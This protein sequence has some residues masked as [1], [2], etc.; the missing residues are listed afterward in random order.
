MSKLGLIPRDWSSRYVCVSGL[1][2][3][4]NDQASILLQQNEN[5]QVE[6]KQS[7][8]EDHPIEILDKP[9]VFCALCGNQ[10]PYCHDICYGRDCLKAI[11]H[12]C[13]TAPK[14]NVLAKDLLDVLRKQLLTFL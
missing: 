6:S 4:R 5:I 2:Q 1:K 7:G 9:V 3:G 8:T 11:M 10:G 14:L 13:T 12:I